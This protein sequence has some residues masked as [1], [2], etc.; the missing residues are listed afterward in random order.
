MGGNRDLRHHA[1]ARIH[2]GNT[3]ITPKRSRRRAIFGSRQ[4]LLG[5]GDRRGRVNRLNIFTAQNCR[6]TH[7]RLDRFLVSGATAQ[8]PGESLAHFGFGGIRFSLDK[9]FGGQDLRRGAVSTLNG[10][11]FNKRVLQG[12]Q[13]IGFLPA[14]IGV[15][16][17]GFQRSDFV[18]LS[19]CGE[20]DPRVDRTAIEQHR[21]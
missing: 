12:V 8:N 10:A 11:G 6:G 15:F 16:A 9:V 20:I 5:R 18:T 7:H 3:R 13:A 17:E 14:L 19:L 21:V 1:R 4:P 2:L